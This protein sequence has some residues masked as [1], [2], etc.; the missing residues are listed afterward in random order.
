[1]WY[2]TYIIHHI[3]P[4]FLFTFAI[5]LS[6]KFRFF[7]HDMGCNRALH[8]KIKLFR[9]CFF[10]D[11]MISIPFRIEIQSQELSECVVDSS[12]GQF[13]TR[14]YLEEQWNRH[15]S[16][17]NSQRKSEWVW[18]SLMVEVVVCH[19]ITHVIVMWGVRLHKHC[20]SYKSLIHCLDFFAV[21]IKKV[22]LAKIIW[23]LKIYILVNK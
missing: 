1:M 20:E 16:A 4:Q 21:V 9:F 15:N 10:E 13:F 11:Q 8:T 3:F 22:V 12:D 17:I 2:Y 18:K 23:S 7:S 5:D 6:K 14:L 19:P